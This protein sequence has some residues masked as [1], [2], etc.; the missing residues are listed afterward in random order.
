MDDGRVEEIREKFASKSTEILLGRWTAND[1]ERWSPEAFEAMRM[2]LEERGVDVPPQEERDKER[3][4]DDVKSK[5]RRVGKPRRGAVSF[6]AFSGIGAWIGVIIGGANHGILG[7]M[8]GAVLGNILVSSGLEAQISEI[9]AERETRPFRGAIIVS[10]VLATAFTFLAVRGA[11]PLGSF[12]AQGDEGPDV[13][14]ELAIKYAL[15]AF[16]GGIGA[17]IPLWVSRSRTP[18]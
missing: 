14:I 12:L 13:L 7:A 3:A 9:T 18:A 11:L 5:P 15:P 17:L 4:P 1:R 6:S 8:V 10:Y 16:L 2:I